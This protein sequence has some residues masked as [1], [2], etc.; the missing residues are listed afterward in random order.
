MGVAATNPVGGHLEHPAQK[1]TPEIQRGIICSSLPP[2]V[3]PLI[4]IESVIEKHS[5]SRIEYMIKVSDRGQGQ[6]PTSIGALK[7]RTISAGGGG[8]ENIM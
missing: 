8:G 3:K 2:Q 7:W 6:R 4:W 1:L 5:H